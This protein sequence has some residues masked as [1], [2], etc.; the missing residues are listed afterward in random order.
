MSQESYET[1]LD[2]EWEELIRS[3]LK[4]GLTVEEIREFFINRINHS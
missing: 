4:I 2:K 3:A 1:T